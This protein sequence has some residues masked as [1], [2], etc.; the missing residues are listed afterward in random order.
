[1]SCT[2]HLVFHESYDCFPQSS[3]THRCFGCFQI[4]SP[5]LVLHEYDLED[6]GMGNDR[7]GHRNDWVSGT[8]LGMSQSLTKAECGNMLQRINHANSEKGVGTSLQDCRRIFFS[9]NFGEKGTS[10]T[11]KNGE[12]NSFHIPGNCQDLLFRYFVTVKQ[13]FHCQ[14]LPIWCLLSPIFAWIPPQDFDLISEASLK[15]VLADFLDITSLNPARAVCSCSISR[16][17]W[18]DSS[19]CHD[20]FASLCHFP[21]SKFNIF[22]KK[23]SE[24]SHES[25]ATRQLSWDPG[26]FGHLNNA[27]DLH[28]SRPQAKS[29]ALETETSNDLS[30]KK[31]LRSNLHPMVGDTSHRLLP[32]EICETTFA[33]GAAGE[34]GKVSCCFFQL[35]YPLPIVKKSGSFPEAMFDPKNCSLIQKWNQKRNDSL[36]YFE[37][38]YPNGEKAIV[39]GEF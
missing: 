38:S 21:L 15:H 31:K 12:P 23:K 3:D 37:A 19:M 33:C 25:W 39:P 6:F 36:I 28:W 4:F 29:G 10:E 9:P 20:S 22:Y 26:H 24:L 2:T 35:I 34:F 14:V 18:L 7:F 13:H 32:V 1:M 8:N 27:G 17:K 5:T 11:T 16:T 30:Q